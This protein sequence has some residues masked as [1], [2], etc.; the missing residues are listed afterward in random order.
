MS[1]ELDEL[2]K[3]RMEELK[4]QHSQQQPSSQEQNEEQQLQQQIAQ[5][6]QQVKPL[7]TRDA[8]TRYGTIK[9]AYPDRAVQVLVYVAQM[10]QA[11]RLQ[12]VDDDTLKSL[13]KKLTPKQRQSKIN[14]V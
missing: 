12:Q 8:L 7:F 10:A 4:R 11:G 5:L 13:L 9:T 14:R 2:R 6:E 1:S 3:K